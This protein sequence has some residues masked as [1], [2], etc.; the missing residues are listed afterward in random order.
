MLI[1]DSRARLAGMLADGG[2]TP[3][4]MTAADARAL[5]EAYRRFAAIPGMPGRSA[6][7]PG[8]GARREAA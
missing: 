2:V 7:D 6:P 8:P 5:V 4:T 1:R 3:G